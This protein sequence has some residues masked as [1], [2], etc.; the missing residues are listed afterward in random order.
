MRKNKDKADG[1]NAAVL[2]NTPDTGAPPAA[3][4]EAAGNPPELPEAP[5]AGKPA[6]T[7]DAD[8][9]DLYDTISF[10]EIY[11]LGEAY[12]EMAEKSRDITEGK[13][14]IEEIEGGG[15]SEKPEPEEAQTEEALTGRAQPKSGRGDL[16]LDYGLGRRR[17]PANTVFRPVLIRIARVQPVLYPPLHSEFL[18]LRQK[19]FQ[20]G[21]APHSPASSLLYGSARVFF[22]G[23]DR[24]FLN[25]FM[26]PGRIQA[27]PARSA[28]LSAQ[29]S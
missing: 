9:I 1:G 23:V 20:Q 15:D 24:L 26:P 29:A 27:V 14:R 6:E 10:D 18:P 13:R 21:L 8:G 7:A 12:S 5:P 19:G 2:D 25:P 28:R 16:P 22:I 17:S 4:D 11:N 3:F